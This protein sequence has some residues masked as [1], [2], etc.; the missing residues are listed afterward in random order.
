MST[1]AVETHVERRR[2][3]VRADLA[4]VAVG[5]FAEH[6]ALAEGVARRM[7]VRVGDIRVRT[8]VAAMSA[9]AEAEFRAWT[10]DGGKDDPADRIVNALALVEHGLTG[11]DARRRRSRRGTRDA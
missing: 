4:R 2:R 10:R 11:L 6:P 5:L 7:G 1:E 3:L 8:L 9:V